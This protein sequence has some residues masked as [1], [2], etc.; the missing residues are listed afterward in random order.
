LRL[1]AFKP[2]MTNRKWIGAALSLALCS[3]ALASCSVKDNQSGQA[4]SQQPAQGALNWNS[5]TEKQLLDAIKQAP[6]NG[7][8]PELF[9]QSDLPKDDAQRYSALTDAGLRYAEALAH[10]Y[11]D[12]TK[13][14]DVYT[15]P[16]ASA[17]VRQGLAQAIQNGNVSEYLAS[18][19]PQTDEYK[20]LSQ[21]HLHYL[22]LAGTGQFQK[23]P[24]GKPIKPGASDPRV[25]AVAAALRIAG[26]LESPQSTATGQQQPAAASAST[27]YSPQMVAAVKQL[28]ADFGF[29]ADG[30]VGGDTL[31]ALNADPGYRARQTAVAMERLR[32]L[33]RDPP[34]TRI[35]V[36]TAAA[37]LD[38]W[39]DGQHIDHRNVIVG[40]GDK[41]TP[42]LQAPIYRLVANPTWTVPKGI[43]ENELAKKSP[44]WLSENNFA[45][46]DGLYV[47]GSGP[48]NSLGLVKFDMDDKQAIYLHDTPEKAWFGQPERHRSHGCVRVENALQLASAIADH[49][50]IADDFQKAMASNEETFVKMPNKIPV[51][52]LYHTAYWDGRQVQFRPDIYNW[53]T[54]VARALKLEPGPAIRQKQPESSD[55]GP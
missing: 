54:N 20:A 49:Q 50:G 52:L 16:R 3:T 2:P 36:N 1:A 32:W 35:D 42:Q 29:K 48:K 41:P 31:D 6:A 8:K 7:L 19:A 14:I 37:F 51:R 40:E 53:D 30:I 44:Q 11:A 39:R 28:Q 25:P 9:L 47:Q 12:P 43:G 5:K 33:Q 22:Q 15:I 27:R 24:Q 34:K 38:F 13:L 46:K 17:D 4:N 55:I 45:L 21:A 18:L 26:Y 10:G 23:V